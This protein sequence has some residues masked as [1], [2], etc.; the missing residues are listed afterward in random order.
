MILRIPGVGVQS[1]RMIVD[2]RRYRKLTAF[3]LKKI[4]IVMK[5]ARYFITNN[6]LPAYIHDLS[7]NTLKKHII[8]ENMTKKRKSNSTQLNLFNPVA[9]NNNTLSITQTAH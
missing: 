8:T 7:P 6:E 5:R 3:H 2:A 1:A 4:G 9:H